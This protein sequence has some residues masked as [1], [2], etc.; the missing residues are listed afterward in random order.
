[1]T[2]T[3]APVMRT[4]L[5]RCSPER[6]FAVFT[7]EMTNWWPLQS[8]SVYPTE[9]STVTFD[10]GKL[11]ETLADGRSD[12]WGEVLTWNPPSELSFTWHPGQPS[13]DRTQVTVRFTAEADGTRVDLEHVGWEVFA[14]QAQ[15][16]RE[17]YD[18]EGGWTQVLELFAKDANA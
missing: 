4:V 5:V 6:A 15:E 18:S 2:Q 13:G 1:M 7:Q 8:H 16:R 10:N 3:L 17:S 11:I 9:P 12:V 14:D